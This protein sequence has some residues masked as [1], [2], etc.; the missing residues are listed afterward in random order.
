MSYRTP[1]GLLTVRELRKALDAAHPDQVVS[2]SLS[3]DDIAAVR[4]TVPEGLRLVF[5]VE[6]DQASSRGP[7]FKLTSGGQQPTS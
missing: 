3:D 4:A 6:I 7:V 1:P 5:S 2:F